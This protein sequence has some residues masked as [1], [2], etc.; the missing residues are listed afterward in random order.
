MVRKSSR[1]KEG[2]L[3][4][5]GKRALYSA[6]KFAGRAAKDTLILARP[7][8]KREEFKFDKVKPY[9]ALNEINLLKRRVKQEFLRLSGRVHHF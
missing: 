6:L 5:A 3:L 4:R 2:V 1:K 8:S 9:L 7:L